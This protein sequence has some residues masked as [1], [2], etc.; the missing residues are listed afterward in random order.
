[1]LY[2]IFNV[3]KYSI[4]M[5]VLVLIILV[6]LTGCNLKSNKKDEN[7]VV[8]KKETVERFQGKENEVFSYVYT[9]KKEVALTFDGLGD[10]DTM[11]KLLSELKKHQIKATFFLPGI[12]V[13]E[14]P[15]LV[16]K[17]LE[18]GHEIENNTL[19]RKDL[20]KLSYEEIYKEIN[21]TNEIIKRET[22][23]TSKYV[24]PRGGVYNKDVQLVSAQTGLKAVI[25]YNIYPKDSDMKSA[26]EI[27]EYIKKYISRGGIISLNSDVNPE[28]INAIPFIAEA[29]NEIGYKY[30][31]LEELF[32]GSY[33]KKPLNMI[34][35]YDS[36]KINMN[37]KS[38]NKKDIIYSVNTAK[39]QVALTFDDW[40]TDYTITKILDI[41]KEK[42]VK[43]T[44]FL[45]GIGVENNPNL[46]KAI[47]EDGH[48][49]GNHTYS[50]PVITKIPESQLQEEIIK[51]HMTLTEA[52]QQQPK[53][54]FRPPTG[55]INNKA[56]SAIV[57]TGYRPILYD[58]SAHDWDSKNSAEDITNFIN[59]NTKKGSIILL[60]LQEGTN[61]IEAL[62]KVIDGIR[63]RGYS[64]VDLSELLGK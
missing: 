46:A 4:K 30:V 41:L 52:I 12:R 2:N 11:N 29:A 10:E 40:G 47:L 42:D 21:K 59:K 34:E 58:V 43:S 51:C 15:K 61:T 3:K 54:Y 1:M 44:F 19:D 37:Y 56:A 32:K 57:A 28:V 36:A 26:K 64:I 48:E 9:T 39:K 53:L 23:I 14:E 7:V 63:S 24:R 62:P 8:N 13:A 31:T 60:H 22:G 20:T 49:I 6:A 33:E 55:E 50:H 18:D 16:K 25:T 5:I 35:G 27:G 45:K 38:I 17:I